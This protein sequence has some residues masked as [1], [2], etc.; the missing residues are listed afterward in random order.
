MLKSL[1]LVATAAIVLAGCGS[2]VTVL[3]SGATAGTG[4]QGG[5][6]SGSGAGATGGVSSVDVAQASAV[7]VG[8]GATS[9]TGSGT[10]PIDPDSV[11]SGA[12]KMLAQCKFMRF[13]ECMD[14][15][16]PDLGDCSPAELDTLQ[17]CLS[18][19]KACSEVSVFF[20]CAD[21][22]ACVRM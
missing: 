18:E 5:A 7:A 13:E 14:D 9:S 20:A 10:K 3:T 12:C 2:E 16:L 22:V 19:F 11:C 17:K 15:C 8:P 6:A 1:S 21:A 4:G